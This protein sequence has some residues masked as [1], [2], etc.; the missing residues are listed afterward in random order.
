M[1]S[2]KKPTTDIKWFLIPSSPLSH[3]DYAHLPEIKI[4]MGKP[5]NK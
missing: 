5:W 3:Y 1:S 2:L 4:K